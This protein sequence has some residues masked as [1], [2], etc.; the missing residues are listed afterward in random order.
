VKVAG[1]VPIVEVYHARGQGVN[2]GLRWYHEMGIS[3]ENKGDAAQRFSNSFGKEATC[4]AN[5][6]RHANSSP[7]DPA[8]RMHICWSSDKNPRPYWSIVTQIVLH[9]FTRKIDTPTLSLITMLV[10]LE[11]SSIP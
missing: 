8:L 2:K 10:T 9:S 4:F 11:W 7:F 6:L 5:K 3:S 1:H